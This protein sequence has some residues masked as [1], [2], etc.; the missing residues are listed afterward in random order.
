M[1]WSGSGL[2]LPDA[3]GVVGAV[4]PDS[5]PLLSLV[6]VLGAAIATGNAIILVPGQKYPL[7]ALTFIQVGTAELYSLCYD[8]EM[9]RIFAVKFSSV[10]N[11][12]ESFKH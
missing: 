11:V 8:L 12:F 4:L 7:P 5:N 9:E 3:L 6:T 10:V 1:L 2:S